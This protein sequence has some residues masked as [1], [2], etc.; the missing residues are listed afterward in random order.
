MDD[1]TEI[2][3]YDCPDCEWSL[4]IEKRVWIEFDNHQDILDYIQEKVVDHNK[5]LGV[6]KELFPIDK[7][8]TTYKESPYIEYTESDS[9]IILE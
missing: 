7:D 3:D 6:K 9:L 4:H 1:Y 2:E 5:T 8:I